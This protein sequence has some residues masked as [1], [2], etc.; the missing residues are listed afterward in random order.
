MFGSGERLGPRRG[1]K[2]PDDVRDA[3]DLA[4]G[5]RVLTFA[6]DDNTGAQVVATTYRFVVATADTVV[7]QRDWY[8]V[9]AGQWDPDTWTLTVTWVDGRHAGQYTFRGQDTRLPE[10]FHERVQA[11]V[12]LASP[13]DLP[14]PRRSGRVVIRKDLRD[15]RLFEQTVLG[16]Q[17]PAD[18]PAVLARIDQLTAQ[19][20]DQVGL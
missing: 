8:D 17:T 12:V 6:R 4:R 16:R 3:L 10:T 11:S 18:D 13:L 14:G 2:L 1:P 19:L 5:E 15:G 20:R 9:D 7:M